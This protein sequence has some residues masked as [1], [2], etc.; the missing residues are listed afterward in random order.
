MA[1]DVTSPPEPGVAHLVGGI[2]EDAQQLMI[3]Q[4]DLLKAD[5]RKDLR[6]ARE[7]GFHLGVGGVLLGVGGVLL[8][9]M[10]VHFLSGM[11]PELPLWGS[12]G[13]VGGLLAL[14]GGIVF[15]RGQEQLDKI[16][17][18]PEVSVQAMKENLQW[19]TN[20]K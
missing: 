9:F 16:D 4:A 13:L 18:L 14:A 8:L 11:W 19:K 1:T 17:P 10:V 6:D 12:F 7:A 5:I 3:Q 2:F 15:Y 20:P